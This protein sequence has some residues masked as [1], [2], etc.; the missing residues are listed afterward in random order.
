MRTACL[1][2]LALVTLALLTPW[3][4]RAQMA[5][6]APS[7]WLPDGLSLSLGGGANL[8]PA[9]PGAVRYHVQGLPFVDASYRGSLFVTDSTLGMNLM[10]LHGLSAGLGFGLSGGR[11]HTDDALLRD[12]P[13]IG[14]TLQALPYIA[15]TMGEFEIRL[16]AAQ[17]VTQAGQGGRLRASLLWR[18]RFNRLALT[19]G[20]EL[21]YADRDYMRTWFGVSDATASAEHIRAYHPGGG[22]EDAGVELSGRY[23]LT[24]RWSI[25][26]S[27]GLHGLLH[28]A[29]V[30]PIVRTAIQLHAGA[31]VAYHF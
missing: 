31:G 21:T 26:F 1:P 2:A 4:A 22:L 10:H 6:T 25:I 9:Y 19:L 13:D 14:R 3:A 23:F 18:H 20:P 27:T 30:S 7:A 28:Q 16:R 29:S 11:D 15:Y 24:D 12:T 8:T 17:A 5:E